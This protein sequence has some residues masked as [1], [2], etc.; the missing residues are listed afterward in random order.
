VLWHDVTVELHD[1]PPDVGRQLGLLVQH[2][3]QAIVPTAE[4]RLGVHRDPHGYRVTD[5]GDDLATVPDARGVLDTVFARVHRRAFELAALSGWVRLHGVV[6]RVGERRLVVVGDSGAGKTTLAVAALVAGH[7]VEGDESLLVRAGQVVAVPRRF[8]VKPGTAEV[9]PR[10][11]G[12]LAA[13]PLL[14]GDP[15]LRLLDPTEVGRPWHLPVARVD[16]VVLL[17]R[18]GGPSR[19]EGASAT[20]V[21]PE[22]MAQTFPTVESRAA[23]VREVSGLLR[24]VTV[25]RLVAGTD[26]RVLEQLEIVARLG[27]TG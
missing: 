21:A 25:H 23:V 1:T 12:W 27:G 8:H 17:R 20:E 11:A 19:R 24:D 14:E 2:A 7:E 18:A 9:V 4:V 6:L 5:R 22:V 10:A 15:P 13:A 26:G 16:D 3:D